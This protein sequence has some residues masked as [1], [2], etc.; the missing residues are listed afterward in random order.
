MTTIIKINFDIIQNPST[1]ECLEQIQDNIGIL[2]NNLKTQVLEIMGYG[3]GFT[4]G[5][6]ALRNGDKLLI[7]YNNYSVNTQTHTIEINLSEDIAIYREILTGDIHQFAYGNY[8]KLDRNGVCHILDA[9][10]EIVETFDRVN[11]LDYNQRYKMFYK[12]VV[13]GIFDSQTGTKHYLPGKLIWGCQI[14]YGQQKGE[15]IFLMRSSGN[16]N[17]YYIVDCNGLVFENEFEVA[18]FYFNESS[19]LESFSIIA[20]SI[21]GSLLLNLHNQYMVMNSKG[22]FTIETDLVLHSFE[23][24]LYAY[25]NGVTDGYG[26]YKKAQHSTSM[27]DDIAQDYI[28]AESYQLFGAEVPELALAT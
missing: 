18:S 14:N 19:N 2:S 1:W 24:D 25:H 21:E 11:C 27:L 12:G 26:C 8:F 16:P 9:N 7:Q 15:Q 6:H 13:N 5:L 10:F 28:G 20:T 4:P 22:F 17:H 3:S 23:S